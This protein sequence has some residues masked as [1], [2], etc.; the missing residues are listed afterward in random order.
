M[1]NIGERVICINNSGYEE[2]LFLNNTYTI[3]SKMK[4]IIYHEDLLEFYELSGAFYQYR[5]ISTKEQRKKKLEK[6][7]LKTEID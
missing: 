5:F 2:A 4:S 3:M 7:C 1:F 6:L